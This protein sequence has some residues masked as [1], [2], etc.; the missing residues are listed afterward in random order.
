MQVLVKNIYC[1]D[2]KSHGLNPYF[3]DSECFEIGPH[4]SM[5]SLLDLTDSLGLSPYFVLEAK[6][7]FMVS[8]LG[9]GDIY[10]RGVGALTA[11]AALMKA[12]TGYV[13]GDQESLKQYIT[14]YLPADPIT[15]KDSYQQVLTF[16]ETE[17]DSSVWEKLRPGGFYFLGTDNKT[18]KLS[19]KKF[20]AFGKLWPS[21]EPTEF[22]WRFGKETPELSGLEFAKIKKSV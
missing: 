21:G 13:S 16:G 15:H 7:A 17:I 14:E 3:W 8:Q 5:S 4:F 22:G 6:M 1:A 18:M 12:G 10:L 9:K 19:D 2:L 20:E 11:T